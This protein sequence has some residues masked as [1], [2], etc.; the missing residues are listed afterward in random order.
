[1][2]KLYAI[3]L[4]LAAALLLPQSLLAQNSN[5]DNILGMYYYESGDD[6]CRVMIEKM[7]DGSYRGTVCWT[8]DLYDASG[9]KKTD[10]KNPDKSLRNV[11]MDQVVIFSGLRYNPEKK[12]WDGGKIYDP[13]RG[14]RAKM[15]ARFESEGSLS[16]RGSVMGIG[17]T[18]IWTKEK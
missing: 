17:E 11:P 15:T 14:I 16:I 12:N 13:R 9:K 7:P 1:M 2:K 5:A 6:A 4:A 10:V 3:L 8:N 18:V